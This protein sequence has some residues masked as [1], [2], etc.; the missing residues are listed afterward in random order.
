MFTGNDRK[1]RASQLSYVASS[2]NTGREKKCGWFPLMED[3]KEREKILDRI[4]HEQNIGVIFS[5]LFV[6]ATVGIYS[7]SIMRN[8]MEISVKREREI[9]GEI[10]YKEKTIWQVRKI[11]EKLPLCFVSSLSTPIFITFFFLFQLLFK[12]IYWKIN[13]LFNLVISWKYLVPS[14]MNKTKIM[15]S[16]N[17]MNNKYQIHFIFGNFK[18]K[19]RV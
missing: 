3:G 16:T 11:I 5:F 17:T 15:W 18:K 7:Q 14:Q 10:K 9:K 12:W 8:Q 19:K 1:E 13:I 2:E 6:A 4:G